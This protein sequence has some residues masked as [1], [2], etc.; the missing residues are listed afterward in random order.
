MR[1]CSNPP[2]GRELRRIQDMSR[3]DK[4]AFAL[5]M[6]RWLR[7]ARGHQRKPDLRALT[8]PNANRRIRV[9]VHMYEA[10]LELWTWLHAS[11]EQLLV[12]LQDWCRC[13][14]QSDI[15]A[16]AYFSMRLRRY[17]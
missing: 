4:R 12:Q 10:L 7:Q 2:A 9:Y 11:H 16:I 17:A 8:S 13:T 14:E 5:G 6:K 3:D 1:A 15:K